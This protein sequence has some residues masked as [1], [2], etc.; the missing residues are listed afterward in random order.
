MGVSDRQRKGSSKVAVIWTFTLL[1]LSCRLTRVTADNQSRLGFVFWR[2]SCRALLPSCDAFLYDHTPFLAVCL[3]LFPS[4]DNSD[5]TFTSSSVISFPHLLTTDLSSSPSHIW[6]IWHQW[7]DFSFPP[8]S[9]HIGVM[10]FIVI[11]QEETGTRVRWQGEFSYPHSDSLPFP[12]IPETVT[13]IPVCVKLHHIHSQTEKEKHR[14]H[15]KGQ[16][17]PYQL[18]LAHSSQSMKGK[19]GGRYF[20][21]TW[22]FTLIHVEQHKNIIISV[23]GAQG[24]LVPSDRN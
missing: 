6:H 15:E 17:Q 3:L 1:R 4:S 23:M 7:E 19:R 11:S 12:F 8:L 20:T 14:D 24:C 9:K 13:P 10:R 2:W 22:H 16:L 21:H 18:I 5:K